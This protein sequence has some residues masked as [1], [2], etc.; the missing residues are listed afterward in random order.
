MDDIY[1]VEIRLGRTRWRVNKTV[2]DIARTFGIVPFMER[3]P[4]VTL[5]GPFELADEI[6]P[7]QLID[8]I[9]SI[10]SRYDPIPFLIGDFEKRKG[11]HGSVIAFSVTPS[12]LLTGLTTELVAALL[13]LTITYNAWDATPDQKWY[14]VTIANR[15]DH[16]V[17]DSVYS[18]LTNDPAAGKPQDPSGGVVFRL[19]ARVRQFLYCGSR[20]SIRPLLLDETGLRITLLHGDVILAEY[21]LLEKRWIHDDHRQSG[22]GWQATLARFRQQAGFES[23]HPKTPA[24]D[25]ILLLADLHLGHAN[26]IRYCSRPFFVLDPGEMDRVLIANWNATVPEGTRAYHLGDF[27]YGRDAL[28][29]DA[30]RNQMTGEITFIAGNHDPGR[31]GLLASAEIEHDGLKFFLIHDPVDAP[32]GFDGWIVH[33]HHHNNDLAHYPF[34]DFKH[35]RI[36]VSAEVTGYVPVSLSGICELIRYRNTTGNKEPV[37]LHYPYAER[38]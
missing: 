16:A 8:A 11:M 19:L 34:I 12:D 37:L 15:L 13:P 4:H 20:Y 36:N 7:S 5:F 18:A 9:G 6:S 38:T 17:A 14:H 23:P 25:D 31:P 35:R 32:T 26:I 21:D 28:P 24:A 3:H 30:Y 33:G 27:Y 1:L 2:S 10:A 22:K 29:E